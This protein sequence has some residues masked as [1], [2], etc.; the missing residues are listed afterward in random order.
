MSLNILDKTVSTEIDYE[1]LD[2]IEGNDEAL[3]K[4]I[5]DNFVDEEHKKKGG[6]S[7]ISKCKGMRQLCNVLGLVPSPDQFIFTMADFQY[8]NNQAVAGAGKTTFSQLRAIKE[9]FLNKIKGTEILCIAY[10]RRAAQDMKIRH[11]QLIEKLLDKYKNTAFKMDTYIET[12]TYHSFAN[13]LVDEYKVEY[14]SK[15]GVILKDKD[16]L[17]TDS[18]VKNFMSQA[19]DRFLKSVNTDDMMIEKY[20][21]N[22]NN[23]ISDLISMYAWRVETLHYDFETAE[24]VTAYQNLIEVF[25]SNGNLIS[26]FELYKDIKRERTVCDYSDLLEFCW[27][28]LQQKPVMLRIRKLFKY[29]IFDEFQDA[30]NSMF[31]SISLICK[32]DESIGIPPSDIR[33]TVI[34]DSDQMLYSF[35]G[36]ELS[37]SLK[38]KENFG[39]DRS[40]ILSM[41]LNRRCLQ[42][43]VELSGDIIK[44]NKERVVKPIRAYRPV[45]MNPN[46]AG[47]S[48]EE[49]ETK[50]VRMFPYKRNT[51]Y[52]QQ[53]VDEVKDMNYLELG[54]TAIIYR[55]K[56]SSIM[57][58]RELFK[59]RIPFKVS[60]GI[61]PYQDTFSK[62]IL[63]SLALLSNPTNSVMAS[64]NLTKLLPKSKG[65]T[66]AYIRDVCKRERIRFNADKNAELLNFWDYNFGVPQNNISWHNK[67]QVLRKLSLEVKQGKPMKELVPKIV[68]CLEMRALKFS[69]SMPP[70]NCLAD[71]LSDFD[72][73][74]SYREF[75][76]ELNKKLEEFK[77]R[78]ES[79]NAIE[80]TTFHSTKGLEFNNVYI[81]DMDDDQFPGRELGECDKDPEKE[82]IALESCRRLLYVAVTRA[83]NNLTIFV[84]ANN[85]SRLIKEFPE[86]FVPEDVERLLKDTAVEAPKEEVKLINSNQNQYS[87]VPD[88]MY[89]DSLNVVSLDVGTYHIEGYFDGFIHQ[90]DYAQ[91]KLEEAERNR[92]EEAASN[93]LE[94]D[95]FWNMFE[96]T[97][98]D[99]VVR[100]DLEIGDKDE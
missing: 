42:P 86:K 24:S 76:A 10:N 45:S 58:S 17:I 23:I 59:N 63:G 71:I 69:D 38:F 65:I 53:I 75:N 95:T 89:L 32:G 78:A 30:S 60:K 48:Y 72:S 88:D 2:S 4:Y 43:I 98:E 85:P 99:S 81:I 87:N 94:E 27:I 91:K 61:S 56:V 92:K 33:L 79:F 9:K 14:A 77:E 29:I 66:N 39:E 16:Y 80:L 36:V 57:I 28:L 6:H 97:E 74:L 49:C 35:R 55:N 26:I 3:Y 11:A 62:A 15:L 46:D 7:F 21:K 51:E 52:L 67:M 40:K 31:R 44:N 41:A 82:E 13:F 34:G 100:E 83:R 70:D 68:D 8:I 54:E 50:A 5:E 25:Y 20:K 93:I 12:Y 73:E 22:Y 84:D 47:K 90:G 37:T 96:G 64:E 1:Y 19:V 18:Q